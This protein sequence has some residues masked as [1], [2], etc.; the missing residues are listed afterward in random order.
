MKKSDPMLDSIE[1]QVMVPM[2]IVLFPN[3]NKI[4]KQKWQPG[5]VKF[6]VEVYET[7]TYLNVIAGESRI[8]NSIVQSN[9]TIELTFN[10]H[11]VS[12]KGPNV[13]INEINHELMMMDRLFAM[14]LNFN[15][16][17]TI[18][19]EF[20]KRDSLTF[21]KIEYIQRYKNKLSPLVY[22][23]MLLD[24]ISESYMKS[25]Y[26]T[27]YIR[28]NDIVVFKEK[29]YEYNF[30]EKLATIL[31]ELKGDESEFLSLRLGNALPIYYLF[32]KFFMKGLPFDYDTTV[33]NFMLYQ[34]G[35][36]KEKI[37]SILVYNNRK[38]HRAISSIKHVLQYLSIP[39]YIRT[40]EALYKAY[41]DYTSLTSY[42]LLDIHNEKY[43][44]SDLVGKVVV[45]DFWYTGC[46]ACP[47]VVPFLTRLEHKFKG[48]PVQFISVSID[49]DYQRWRKS[50][51]SGLYTTSNGLSLF[52]GPAGKS[53]SLISDL[54]ITGYPTI[55]VF[56]KDG[57]V[58]RLPKDPR[59][60]NAIDLTNLI[61]ELID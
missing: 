41:S 39:L 11:S 30:P 53:H 42:S 37:F 14:T 2:G 36:L 1:L 46:P 21:S 32:E 56:K 26:L 7:P 34:D 28:G 19:S 43:H 5:G 38:N 57:S 25:T 33:E 35:P 45:L 59:F 13:V 31:E 18:K 3:S 55:I 20:E 10:K 52:T 40:I 16:P 47:E 50:V 49:K 22:K 12:F 61:W 8:V 23:M 44:L 48:N 6:E 27:N 58:A 51:E 24:L 17:S 9:D 29:L 60:D 15:D 54:F 4:Y